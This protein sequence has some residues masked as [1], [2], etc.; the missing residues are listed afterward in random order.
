LSEIHNNLRER[1]FTI[2]RAENHRKNRREKSRK[3]SQFIK[4]PFQFTKKLLGDTR[5]GRLQCP[6]EEVQDYLRKTHDRTKT[7]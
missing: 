1:L 5:S 3:R 4:N 7:P 6:R 2:R